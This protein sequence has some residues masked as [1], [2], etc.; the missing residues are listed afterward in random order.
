MYKITNTL[1]I[2][3]LLKNTPNRML[4]IKYMKL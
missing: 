4:K 1:A 3:Y 2:G